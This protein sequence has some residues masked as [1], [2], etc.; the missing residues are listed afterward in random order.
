M[1]RIRRVR[2]ITTLAIA[3]MLWSAVVSADQIHVITSGAFTAAYTRLV[4]EFQRTSPHTVESA[5]GASMG[6]G[7]DSIPSR[8]ERG[9]R[10][11]VV[12]MAASALEV[13]I[14]QGRIVAGSRVDLVRSRI[15]VAVRAGHAKP[16]ISSVA[17][18][19]QT[20]LHMATIA[21]SSSASGVYLSGQLF[22]QLG[23]GDQLKAKLRITGGM[24]GPLVANGDAEIGF[25]QISE[26]LPVP[27]ID[28]IGPLP[29][30]AQQE[31]IF[32][33]GIISGTRV[34]DAARE[35]IAFFTSA[36]AASIVKATGLDPIVAQ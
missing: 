3:S 15:G 21:V 36:A 31:T 7:S 22:P 16:D 23:I 30:G 19:R 28:Y 13:L 25:Q 10:T 32:A 1:G 14:E 4:P 18:L 27:G 2:A 35:L 26:L 8:L 6:S 17:A 29:T 20:L 11:D 9:E 12:I 33:A 34:F 24:V 5:F